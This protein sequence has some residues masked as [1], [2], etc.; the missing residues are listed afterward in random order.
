MTKPI[1]CDHDWYRASGRRKCKNCG[2]WW[3]EWIRIQ[4]DM[5][6]ETDHWWTYRAARV[7]SALV[8][9]VFGE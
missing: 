1:E 6:Q 8:E 2:V 7:L 4:A 5:L 9:E 3:S